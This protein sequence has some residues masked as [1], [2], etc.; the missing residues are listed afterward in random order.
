MGVPT[1]PKNRNAA[2]GK[3]K[4]EIF[5]QLREIA[6]K[7]P[8]FSGSLEDLE[9]HVGLQSQ[10]PGKCQLMNYSPG[11]E[12]NADPVLVPSYEANST[13]NRSCF[14]GEV[15]DES[16]PSTFISSFVETN[17]LVPDKDLDF[18]ESTSIANAFQG[19]HSRAR[20]LNT[21]ERDFAISRALSIKLIHRHSVESPFYPGNINRT[22]RI[23]LLAHSSS[24]S[25]FSKQTKNTTSIRPKMD[26]QHLMYMIQAGIGTFAPPHPPYYNYFLHLD[27]GNELTWTQ[28]DECRKSG[29][30]DCFQQKPPLFPS[31][32]STS[33]RPLPCDKHSLCIPGECIGFTCSYEI[34]YADEARSLG[35]LARETFTF[36]SSNGDNKTERVKD[37][38]F[39]CG[40]RNKRFIESAKDNLVAGNFGL[41]PGVY[42]FLRQKRSLTQGRFSYCLPPWDAAHK[43]AV[44]LRFGSDIPDKKD[45]KSTRC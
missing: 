5:C 11:L 28:C 44:F 7:D 24:S 26:S 21:Q 38:V 45:F 37:M 40:I 36:A 2:C 8:N 18:G 23:N 15:P 41:G 9:L 39:G 34:E 16:F 33:Y 35:Y 27:T 6:K 31:A 22:E 20:E 29:Q 25:R 13:P 30:A 19:V 14:N 1:L 17:H 12:N 10:V 3:H 43:S 32:R 4:E 42:S